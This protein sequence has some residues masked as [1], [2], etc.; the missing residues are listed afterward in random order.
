[1]DLRERRELNNGFGDGLAHAFELAVTPAIFGFLGHL[2]DR[3]LHTGFVAA[4]VA[5]LLAVV[6]MFVKSWYAYDAE[7][8]AREADTPWGRSQAARAARA[9]EG[10]AA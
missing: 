4:L 1:M 7:M 5:F 8:K 2:V 6:G 3:A 9:R 10:H